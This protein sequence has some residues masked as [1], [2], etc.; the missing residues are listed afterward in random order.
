MASGINMIRVI[1]LAIGLGLSMPA[2]VPA[3]AAVSAQS[4]RYQDA[5]QV[6][7]RTQTD[8]ARSVTFLE[9]KHSDRDRLRNAQKHLST[10]DR[11]LAKGKFDK[12]TLNSA[13]G[14][15]QSVLDHNVLQSQDRD[16][17]MQDVSDLRNI[18]SDHHH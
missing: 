14:D 5:R 10:L 18:R 8:L 13:I 11:H 3:G 16:A 1:A 4:M 12:D 17:L 7:S 9:K 15:I 6:V 2:F